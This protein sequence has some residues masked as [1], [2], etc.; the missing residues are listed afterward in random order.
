[1]M[2]NVADVIFVG[3]SLVTLPVY[4]TM[5]ILLIRNRKTTSFCI[6]FYWLIISQGIADL[7]YLVT[8]V[9][10][11]IFAYIA[12]STELDPVLTRIVTNV[13]VKILTFCLALRCLGIM[14]ISF[15]RYTALCLWSSTRFMWVNRGSPIR[16][17][18]IQWVV[19]AVVIFPI[20]PLI[21]SS[22]GPTREKALLFDATSFKVLMIAMYVSV[23]PTFVIC[24]FCYGAVL[25]EIFCKLRSVRSTSKKVVRE[26]Q[27][28][29]QAA[30]FVFAFFLLFAFYLYECILI[31][32]SIHPPVILQLIHPIVSGFLSFV[33]PWTLVF[34][35]KEVAALFKKIFETAVPVRAHL[36]SAS[37]T[38]GVK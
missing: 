12:F 7:L 37:W 28:C 22:L 33:V 11:I 8:Y 2:W 3:C 20:L 14:L 26:V 19:S 17:V 38:T 31:L 6:P 36:P 16:I 24:I 25:R 18:A 32:N 27:L 9:T 30:A 13:D 4:F 21:D 15:Q 34:F 29:I 23:F 35:N 5:L 10:F 1:Q